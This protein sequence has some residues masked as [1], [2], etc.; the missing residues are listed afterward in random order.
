MDRLLVSI[1]MG[2]YDEQP[3]HLRAAINS[4]LNQSYSYI[5]LITI[6]D[7]PNNDTLATILHDY[8]LKDPRIHYIKN[9]HNMGR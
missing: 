6:L 7:K 4:V 3:T 1:I 9:A 8:S 5:E 2:V